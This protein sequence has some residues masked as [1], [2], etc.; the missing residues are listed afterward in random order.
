GLPPFPVRVGADHLVELPV[1]PVKDQD[2]SV[3]LRIAPALNRGVGRHGVWARVALVVVPDESDRHPRLIAGDHNVRNA[4]WG[5]LPDGAE[6]W[7]EATVRPDARDERIGVRVHRLFGDVPIPS[8]VRWEDAPSAQT[9]PG[10]QARF[11]RFPRRLGAGSALTAGE[12]HRPGG[13]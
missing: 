3:A 5:S 1:V 2:V 6:V 9:G 12:G 4:Q 11:G 10:P 8:V 13:D 7:V